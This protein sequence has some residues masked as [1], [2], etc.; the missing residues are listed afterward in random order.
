M[1]KV[2]PPSSGLRYQKKR[3]QTRSTWLPPPPPPMSQNNH[4]K[5]FFY[6]SIISPTRYFGLV[7]N[8]YLKIKMNRS[9]STTVDFVVFGS[10]TVARPSHFMARNYIVKN[11]FFCFLNALNEFVRE[12]M[13]KLKIKIKM[14][15]ITL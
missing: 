9:W 3:I 8:T 2:V 12:L 1:I 13:F 10:T 5:H 15:E 11:N 4:T 6:V 7:T 14:I